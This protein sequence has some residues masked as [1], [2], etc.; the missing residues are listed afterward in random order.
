MPGYF[1]L[2]SLR[3]STSLQPQPQVIKVEPLSP[4]VGGW[5][6]RD[7]LPL[8]DPGD[9]II[10]D[11]WIPDTTS[12]HLRSGFSTWATLATTATA[13]ETLIQYVP[14]NTSNAKLFAATS[15]KIW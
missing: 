7:S 1:A 4:P 9:A 14:P 2:R 10:L 15:D 6:V 5:N 8:M 11:N 3:A 13:V 12:L